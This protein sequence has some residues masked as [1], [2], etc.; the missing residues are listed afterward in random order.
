[1]LSQEHIFAVEVE[2]IRLLE[3]KAA[4][5]RVQIARQKAVRMKK[6]PKNAWRQ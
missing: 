1:M 4:V 2:A 5:L 3:A 6:K